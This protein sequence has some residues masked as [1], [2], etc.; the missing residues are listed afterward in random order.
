MKKQKFQRREPHEELNQ[1]VDR[2]NIPDRVT[3]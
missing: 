1:D 3:A 2:R